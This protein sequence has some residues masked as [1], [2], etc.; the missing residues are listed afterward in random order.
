MLPTAGLTQDC[1]E[2]PGGG[3]RGGACE[4]L[5]AAG[6]CELVSWSLSSPWV[7]PWVS[8]DWRRKWAQEAQ[9]PWNQSSLT[10]PGLALPL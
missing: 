1:L 7:A 4:A 8:G 3:A 2:V 9:G 6:L 10:S 5:V